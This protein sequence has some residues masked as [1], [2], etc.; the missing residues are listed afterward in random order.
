MLSYEIEYNCL[1]HVILIDNV[2]T[3][4]QIQDLFALGHDF[5]PTRLKA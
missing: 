3:R 4:V 2:I 5:K 1:F